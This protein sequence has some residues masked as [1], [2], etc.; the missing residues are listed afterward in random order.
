MAYAFGCLP[1]Q[2]RVGRGILFL[3]QFSCVCALVVVS[4]WRGMK[5][6]L[7]FISEYIYSC[8]RRGLW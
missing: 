7:K 6:F 5:S 3:Q 2:W 1:A 4:H 8:A